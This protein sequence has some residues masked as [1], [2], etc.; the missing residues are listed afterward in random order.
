[1]QSHLSGQ[2]TTAPC[3]GNALFLSDLGKE[4]M[5]LSY[6]TDIGR[7]ALEAEWSGIIL[8]ST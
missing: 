4:L 1:M 5:T 3:T 7:C 8:Q 6:G 2:P